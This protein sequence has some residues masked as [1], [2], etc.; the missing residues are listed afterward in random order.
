M[1]EEVY[2][3]LPEDLEEEFQFYVRFAKPLAIKI[4]NYSGEYLINFI[5]IQLQLYNIFNFSDR[6]NASKWVTRLEN[7]PDRKLKND[8]LKLL[9]FA[10]QRPS[11]I[12][13]FNA[14]PSEEPLKQLEGSKVTLL[15]I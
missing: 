1:A 11:L 13:P 4:R 14:P 5:Y 3:V 12:V 6:I 9:L 2:V 15:L 8:Y 7:E 10:M